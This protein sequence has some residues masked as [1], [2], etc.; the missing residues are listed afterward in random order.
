MASEGALDTSGTAATP[1]SQQQPAALQ[2]SPGAGSGLPATSIGVMSTSGS[3]A[4]QAAATGGQLTVQ[5]FQQYQLQQYNQQQA[6][7]QQAV[8][9]QYSKTSAIQV[10]LGV[11]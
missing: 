10:L 8:R 2:S 3:G 9:G 11:W 4:S 5:Q 7:A 1:I 6:K